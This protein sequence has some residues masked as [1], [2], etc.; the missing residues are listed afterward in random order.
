ML[1]IDALIETTGSVGVGARVQGGGCGDNYGS[2]GYFFSVE[3]NGT[4]I[5]FYLASH[6]F[7]IGNWNLTRGNTILAEGTTAFSANKFYRLG[8]AANG[9]NIS[10]FFVVGVVFLF[11]PLMQRKYAPLSIT[12]LS[13]V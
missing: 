1:A 8:I 12:L 6:L 4:G 10:L 13:H 5:T 9:S 2:G 11:F 7:L 3:Q